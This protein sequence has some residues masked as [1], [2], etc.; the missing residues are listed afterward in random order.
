MGSMK[1]P[2]NILKKWRNDKQMKP[3][4]LRRTKIMRMTLRI[5][6]N[7]MMKRAMMKT[8]RKSD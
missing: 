8:K 4:R 6:K 3:T 7:K 2:K 1:V 5:K